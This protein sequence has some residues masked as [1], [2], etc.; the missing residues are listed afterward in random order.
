VLASLFHTWGKGERMQMG[1]S[2]LDVVRPLESVAL[3]I[4]SNDGPSS[5]QFL[6]ALRSDA[7]VAIVLP[8]QR[9]LDS[10]LATPVAVL[11]ASSGFL[12]F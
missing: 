5:L 4:S 12:L 3:V 7:P 9:L 6:R 2:L 1:E 8:E 11:L 10:V